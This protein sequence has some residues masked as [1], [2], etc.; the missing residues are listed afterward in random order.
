ML[1]IRWVLVR[2]PLER[3]NPQALLSTNM[4]MSAAD[5]VRY[6]GRRWQVEVTFE[7]TRRHLGV[8]TQRQWSDLAIVRTTPVLLALFSIV[9]LLGAQ[10]SPAERRR[11]RQSAWY[12]KSTPTFSDT[13]AAVRQH[14]WREMSPEMG[15]NSTV[16]FITSTRRQHMRKPPRDLRGALL[17]R[18]TE[19]LCYAA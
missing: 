4:T 7:E 6:F 8:E 9:T 17:A 14:F 19:T 13:L 15:V 11:A 18:L 10:L 3:F 16:G 5:I 2:D 1:P 12:E